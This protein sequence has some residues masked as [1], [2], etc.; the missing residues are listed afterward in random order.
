[1]LRSVCGAPRFV[2][3]GEQFQSGF[4]PIQYFFRQVVGQVKRNALGRHVA[5]EM[6]QISAAVPS[7]VTGT[8]HGT[9]NLPI[10]ALGICRERANREIGG[11]GVYLFL[12]FS[13]A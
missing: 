9:A 4:K 3:G 7:S 11:P 1:M 12:S 10:G 5:V 13:Y 8:E 2:S 6:R